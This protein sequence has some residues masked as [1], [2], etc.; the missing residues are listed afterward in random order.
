MSVILFFLL[1]FASE[2]MGTVAGFGSSVFFVPLAGFFF[3]F[4]EVLVLTSILHVFSNASKLVLF[5]R[6]V[7]WRLLFLLGIPSTL[8]VI[9]GAYLSTKLEFK[10]TALILGLF[11]I[12][13]SV[14]FLVRP[15]ARFSPTP[16]NAVSAGGVAGFLAGLIG[17]GGAIR[18]LALG[19][20]DLEKNVFVATSAAIDS[21]VDFSRMIVYLRSGYLTRELYWFVPVL[22][23]IAFSGSY[24][25]KILLSKIQ[26]KS[27]RKIVLFLILLIGLTTLGGFIRE[28]VA[29]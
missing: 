26:Q 9:L 24:V 15:K 18:G 16:V 12:W 19:A 23:V 10:F 2:I 22:L 3:G 4:H 6:D 14:F 11:L 21:G 27:F 13:F 1:A 5:G 20:F 7:Q 17:T 25:G 29:N 28:L 8:C